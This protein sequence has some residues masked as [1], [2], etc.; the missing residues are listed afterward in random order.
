MVAV[1]PLVNMR[2]ARTF[3]RRSLPKMFAASGTRL[4]ADVARSATTTD[5][6][7]FVCTLCTQANKRKLPV[8]AHVPYVAQCGHIFCYICA[9]ALR[10]EGLGCPS[11]QQVVAEIQSVNVDVAES[12]EMVVP[13]GQDMLKTPPKPRHRRY[14]P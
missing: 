13:T 7:F 14:R 6:D 2:S 3:L 8:R 12:T 9:A 1:A 5:L 10:M 11:C 4:P